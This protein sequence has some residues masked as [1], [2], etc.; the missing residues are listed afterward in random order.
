MGV[1]D[2][3]MGKP[4]SVESDPRTKAA[5]D[6]IL[7]EL[8]RI[9]G[10]GPINVPKYIAEVPEQRYSG[11]NNLLSAL[12]LDTVSPPQMDTVNIGGINAYSSEPYQEQIEADFA[13][14]YPSL[15][16]QLTNR[17]DPTMTASFQPVARGGG[18][19]GSNSGGVGQERADFMAEHMARQKRNYAD[20]VTA[21]PSFGYGQD[22]KGG[23]V[24]IGYEGGQ[25]D[26]ALAKAAGYTTRKDVNPFDMSF[27]DHIS[28]IGSDVGTMAS[29]VANDIKKTSLIGRIFG[30][31]K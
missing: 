12:G 22:D 19:G 17:P 3:L 11:T 16:D 9:Y 13:E 18:V 25:V 10:Q 8:M 28:Q 14:K 30:G 21:N 4:S 27:G 7:D 15:Y 23:V 24:A 20:G 2:F 26:P 6:F 29:K 31:G 5:R 1:M